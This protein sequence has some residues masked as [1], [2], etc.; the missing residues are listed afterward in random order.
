MSLRVFTCPIR[1]VKLHILSKQLTRTL[2]ATANRKM[3]RDT[4]V[5]VAKPKHVPVIFLKMTT[6]DERGL[7]SLGGFCGPVRSSLFMEG[8]MEDGS[9]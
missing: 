8:R 5:S 1:S 9:G 4:K 2:S 6:L 7:I 3:P